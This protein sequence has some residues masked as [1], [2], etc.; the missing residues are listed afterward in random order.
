MFSLLLQ[1]LLRNSI[2][3]YCSTKV[4]ILYK[5][6]SIRRFFESADSMKT[7]PVSLVVAREA[8]MSEQ[9]SIRFSVKIIQLNF[10][11]ILCQE[12]RKL[13]QPQF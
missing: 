8:L 7:L 13:V 12:E 9:K 1:N 2:V 4:Y 3:L 5:V 6:N 11:R 10:H